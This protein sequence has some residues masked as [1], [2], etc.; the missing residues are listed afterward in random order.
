[1]IYKPKQNK[2]KKKKKPQ[3]LFFVTLIL[4]LKYEIGGVSPYTVVS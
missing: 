3:N 4:N 1:M 2:W